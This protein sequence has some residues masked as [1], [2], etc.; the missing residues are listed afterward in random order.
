MKL[1][2]FN[3]EKS[4]CS[5]NSAFGNFIKYKKQI[6]MVSLLTDRLIILGLP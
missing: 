6:L 3:L 4:F 2:F 1:E 5:L